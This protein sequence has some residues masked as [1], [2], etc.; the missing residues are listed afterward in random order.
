MWELDHKEDWAP[1]NWFFQIVILEKT[2]EGPLD[3]K[4]SQPVNPKGNQPWRVI[5][6][7]DA[8]AEVPILWPPGVSSWLIGKDLDVGRD[9]RQKEKGPQRRKWLDRF[10]N[11]MDESLSKLREMKNTETWH[12]A[13][14]G[15]A[16]SRTWL[17]DW[18]T[19]DSFY[20]LVSGSATPSHLKIRK[21]TRVNIQSPGEAAD[22]EVC[23]W[24]LLFAIF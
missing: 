9:W 11:S 20:Y 1:K 15:V 4:E 7:T 12:A 14:R 8:E 24:Y 3:C 18:T 19:T 17:R 22:F 13:V 6:R 16:K 2:L 23:L 5:G 10:T 21:Y